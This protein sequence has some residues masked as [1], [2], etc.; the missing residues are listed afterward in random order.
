MD[1]GAL[2]DHCQSIALLFDLSSPA[3]N[4][5]TNIYAQGTE[6]IQKVKNKGVEVLTGGRDVGFCFSP[7]S[8]DCKMSKWE[9]I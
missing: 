5:F 2:K 6:E 1:P 7:E 8:V 3:R 9:V 4:G